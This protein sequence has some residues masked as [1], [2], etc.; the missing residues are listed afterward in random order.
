EAVADEKWTDPL[1]VMLD[2][3]GPVIFLGGRGVGRQDQGSRDGQWRGFHRVAK[4]FRWMAGG[5][6]VRGGGRNDTRTAWLVD[7]YG[8]IRRPLPDVPPSNA[9]NR[10]LLDRL[11]RWCM[12]GNGGCFGSRSPSRTPR[13]RRLAFRDSRFCCA[14]HP[15]TGEVN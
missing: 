10:S 3:P 15:T 11:R 2:V 7:H 12:I 6:A 13:S 9:M 8:P 5:T 4:L 14:K 1:V